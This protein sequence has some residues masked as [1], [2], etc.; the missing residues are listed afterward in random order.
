MPLMDETDSMT[1]WQELEKAGVQPVVEY[2][3]QPI[4]EALVSWWQQRPAQPETQR[5]QGV[6]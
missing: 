5:R 6:A 2:A 1:P 3:W 4:R